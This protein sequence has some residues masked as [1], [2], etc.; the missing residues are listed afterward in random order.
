MA[1]SWGGYESL[2]FPEIVRYNSSSKYYNDTEFL[3][4]NF[5]RF[6]IGLED[7]KML[8]NDLKKALN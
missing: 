1:C 7:E 5:I 4:I 8:I 6:Y 2:I 3:P